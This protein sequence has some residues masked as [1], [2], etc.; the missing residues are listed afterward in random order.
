MIGTTVAISDVGI[1]PETNDRNRDRNKDAIKER[2]N[3]RNIENKNKVVNDY[4]DNKT[5]KNNNTNK[6]NSNNSTINSTKNNTKNNSQVVT[7]VLTEAEEVRLFPEVR[8]TTPTPTLTSTESKN[9]KNLFLAKRT[10]F[11][12]ERKI[13]LAQSMAKSE[14]LPI[15]NSTY[16]S[17]YG[18]SH[19]NTKNKGD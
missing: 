13:L 2:I 6:N 12:K 10:I 4:N 8:M 18:L 11:L 9:L 16:K 7:N 3:S 17:T 5:N 1:K 19:T 15:L 14:S